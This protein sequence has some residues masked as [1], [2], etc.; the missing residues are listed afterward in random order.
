MVAWDRTDTVLLDMDGTLLDLRFDNHFWHEHV[1]QRYAERRGMSAAAARDELI[2]R[3]REVEGTLD[4]YCVDYWSRELDLDIAQLKQE[5]D[6]LI[7]LHAHVHEFLLAL[8]VRG[9]RLWLATNAHRKALAL[10]LART[11]LDAHVD[12]I[13]CAHDL[14]APKETPAFWERLHRA[15]PFDPK[16]SLLI[17]DS[18]PVLRAAQKFGVAQ[19]VT[20]TRPDSTRPE[21]EVGDFFAVTDLRELMPR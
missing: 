15:H 11:G 10:K 21:K 20:I 6:H 14:G 19:L 9:K 17:D 2:A 8:R 3:Y 7:G 1:P 16:T 13:V 5:I 4:W 12:K 18:L